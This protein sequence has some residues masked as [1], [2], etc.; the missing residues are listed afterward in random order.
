M[1]SIFD[2]VGEP[3]VL[4]NQANPEDI[5]GEFAS[6]MRSVYSKMDILKR[7]PDDFR[8]KERGGRLR[9]ILRGAP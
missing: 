3:E 4:Y 5:E 9:H 6:L 7:S 2:E 8:T 1:L